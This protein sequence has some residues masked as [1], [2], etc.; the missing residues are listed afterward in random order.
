MSSAV[1]TSLGVVIVR[2]EGVEVPLLR[3]AV[4]VVERTGA[5]LGELPPPRDGFTLVQ[6]R[7]WPAAEGAQAGTEADE[8]AHEVGGVAGRLGSGEV[9]A[10][11]HGLAGGGERVGRAPR[12]PAG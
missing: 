1:S 12:A 10:Q 9:T 2:A 6:H 11:L 8:R 4:P 7:L 3:V 5:P